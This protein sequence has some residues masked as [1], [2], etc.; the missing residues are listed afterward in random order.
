MGKGVN[1]VNKIR[2]GDLVEVIAGKDKGKRGKILKILKPKSN[3]ESI[4]VIVEGIRLVT[5]SQKPDSQRE[6]PGGLVKKESPLDISN[7]A[8]FDEAT[9]KKSKVGIKTTAE[10]KK[11]RFL[12]INNQV[13]EQA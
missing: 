4:K 9:N 2:T 12:K 11:V 7:V 10:N 6:I 5:K 1:I 8:Y 13:I 3:H